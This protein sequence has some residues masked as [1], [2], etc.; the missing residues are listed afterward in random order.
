MCAA[1]GENV[2][3]SCTFVCPWVWVG[4]W[5]KNLL[6]AQSSDVV[7]KANSSLLLCC[8]FTFDRSQ[9][10][11]HWIFIHLW[12][13]THAADKAKKET[14]QMFFALR[15]KYC[16]ALH[17][18]NCSHSIQ[19]V[20]L[21]AVLQT[22]WHVRMLLHMH[23]Y[24]RHASLAALLTVGF[25]GA[26]HFF[27]IPS[28]RCYW[29]L[30]FV[31]FPI[32]HHLRHPYLNSTTPSSTECGEK[33]Q[34][35]SSDFFFTSFLITGLNKCTRQTRRRKTHI[36][37]SCL[38]HFLNERNVPEHNLFSLSSYPHPPLL[39]SHTRQDAAAVIQV[40]WCLSD[41]SAN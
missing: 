39:T 20:V 13:F 18:Q 40:K 7:G 10:K 26:S 32:L 21:F 12:I 28:Q 27:F 35:G 25:E 23:K 5:L 4:L 22:K 31:C 15:L 2:L 14:S 41:L 38:T 34:L 29:M 6:F 37:S 17:C 30:A 16:T 33:T 8:H 36:L 1:L 9:R 19:A 24:K 11:Y 3:V